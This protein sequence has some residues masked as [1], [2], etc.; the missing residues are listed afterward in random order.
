MSDVTSRHDLPLLAA[1]QAQKE[2]FHNEALTRV[3]ALLHASAIAMGQDVPPSAPQ[4]GESW[5]VGS[6]PSGA[7]SGQADALASWTPGG[8]RFAKPVPGMTVWLIG[9]RVTTRWTGTG[10]EAGSVHADR[11]I[12]GAYQ[13]VST[14]QPAIADPSGGSVVD[15]AARSALTAILAA[16]RQHGLIQP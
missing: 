9:D 4:P 14:R 3:D 5:I 6:D 8:W 11:V 13:V 2:L 7:W 12:I 15:G 16:L 10:W 1:G